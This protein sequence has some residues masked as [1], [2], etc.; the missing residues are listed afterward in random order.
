[1]EAGLRRRPLCRTRRLRRLSQRDDAHGSFLR[2]NRHG[3]LAT[4]GLSTCCCRESGRA[5]GEQIA[6]QVSASHGS[7]VREAWFSSLERSRRTEGIQPTAQLWLCL[8]SA[9]R[10]PGTLLGSSPARLSAIAMP[11]ESHLPQTGGELQRQARP[12][13][14]LGGRSPS[15]KPSLSRARLGGTTISEA[16]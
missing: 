3:R 12:S 9:H 14:R 6:R 8:P 2:Q 1:M 11:K 15:G 13:H 16:Q 10:G 5:G 4:A 7:T